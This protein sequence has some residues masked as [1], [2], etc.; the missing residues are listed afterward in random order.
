MN[1]VTI[2][3]LLSAGAGFGLWA[4]AVYAVPRRPPLATLLTH[5]DSRPAPPPILATEERGWAT[6]LGRPFVSVLRLT[7]LPTAAVR[8]DLAVTGRATDAHLAD[9][10]ALAL[11]GLFLPLGLDLVLTLGGRPL[12]WMMSLLSSL[13]LAVVAFIGFDLVVRREAARR[14]A[15]FRH[16]L[17][18]FLDLI[19]I[20]LAGGAGVDGALSDAAAVGTGWSFAQ[21]RRALNVARLTKTTPWSTLA[22][23]GEELDIA[24]LT[25]LAAALSLAGT[26]GAKVRA[27]LAAKAAALRS[28]GGAEAEAEANSATERM[29]LPAAVMA[30]GFVVF[31]FYPAMAQITASL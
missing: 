3:V 21:L 25:E 2:I 6:R 12:P 27:S 15:T 16:S 20:F 10:A 28:K 19:D 9:Q 22:Q 23:L 4:L 30:L 8:K 7:G 14:R 5:L 13:G 18:A 1:D 31:V 29:S 24:E 17:S 11:T 26:E